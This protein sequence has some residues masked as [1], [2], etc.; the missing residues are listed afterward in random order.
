[1]V[2]PDR[3]RN[4]ETPMG[5][6]DF[7]TFL[8]KNRIMKDFTQEYASELCNISE[9][10]FRNYETNTQTPTLDTLE[11]IAKELDFSILFIGKGGIACIDETIISQKS[12]T[13]FINWG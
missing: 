8:R 4:G 10:T 11:K 9:R 5:T 1:M 12:T 13:C 6:N 3:E 7:S 2:Y